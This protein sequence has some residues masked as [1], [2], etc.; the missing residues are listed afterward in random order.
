ML[1]K[2]VQ[3]VNVVSFGGQLQSVSTTPVGDRPGQIGNK[4]EL[5][6]KW[7]FIAI[8]KSLN[9]IMTTKIVPMTNVACFEAL[10]PAAV[11]K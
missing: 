6:E 1:L 7:R 2:S 11:K 3:F 8:T 4:I 5:D 10:E 9:G